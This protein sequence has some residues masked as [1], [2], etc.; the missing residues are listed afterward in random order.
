[1][2]ES[3]PAHQEDNLFDH[4]RAFTVSDTINERLGHVSASAVSLDLVVGRHKIFLKPPSLITSHMNPRLRLKFF[5]RWSTLSTGIVGNA[6]GECFIEPE[7]IPPSHSDKITEPHV[8]KFVLHHNTKESKL[9]GVHMLLG[10]HDR[11][12]VSNASDIFHSAIFVVGTHDM[13]HLGEG[14]TSTKTFLV[15][16]DCGLGNSEDKLVSHV[17]FQALTHKDS[18]RD[19][20][21]VE[22]FE[23]MI[24]S[25]TNS[26]KISRNSRSLFKHMHR[27]F[28]VLIE[29]KEVF[30]SLSLQNSL[31][32]LRF[33]CE[34]SVNSVTYSDPIL[35]YSNT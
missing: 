27:D 35:G 5:D 24:R 12:S 28:I 3:F 18:L 17:F 10:T 32:F 29:L 31:S 1:M 25:R 8:S 23:D 34:T 33:S 4:A 2:G 13:I 16:L 14:V 15:E 26:E 9:R 6:R 22:V 30:D 19:V 7:V 11:V 20:H 21:G